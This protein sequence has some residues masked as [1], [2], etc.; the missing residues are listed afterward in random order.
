[1]KNLLDYTA[2][3]GRMFLTDFGYSWLRDQGT[4]AGDRHLVPRPLHGA[5]LPWRRLHPRRR[6]ELPQGQGLRRVAHRRRRLED[7]RHAAGARSLLAAARTC[8]NGAAHPALALLRRPATVQ[9]FTFNTPLGAPADKQCGRVVFSNFH[10]EA[11]VKTNPLQ[12]P[13]TFPGQLAASTARSPRRRRPSSS[14]S[15]TPLPA[16]SPTP[17]APRL[18]AAPRGAA[19]A[20]AGHSLTP[21]RHRYT[22]QGFSANV[23]PHEVPPRVSASSSLLD[24]LCRV[25]QPWV[26]RDRPHGRRAG[27]C[28]R[29][30]RARRQPRRRC[31][32]RSRCRPDVAPTPA[33]PH[34]QGAVR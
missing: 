27:R 2:R 26:R 17:T 1:M 14:C 33:L 29:R 30:R 18:R 12:P 7:A 9:H 19:H 10:V 25:H 6:P 22:R 28:G 5:G 21:F 20:P 4:A 3:G 15:S 13:P 34:R 16:S 11:Q 23:R 31:R 8:T 24:R 32:S